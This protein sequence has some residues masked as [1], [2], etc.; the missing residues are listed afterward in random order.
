MKP[1]LNCIDN[2]VSNVSERVLCEHQSVIKQ[3]PCKMIFGCNMSLQLDRMKPK[4][5]AIIEATK[6]TDN[7]NAKSFIPGESVLI[8][9]NAGDGT[10]WIP[11]NVVTTKG[12]TMYTCASNRGQCV[13]QANNMLKNTATKCVVISI[14][15][16]QN[17]FACNF[18]AGNPPVNN[19]QA[20]DPMLSDN[21][22]SIVPA[23][24][25]KR[26]QRKKK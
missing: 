25:N 16:T 6:S 14:D 18:R 9:N 12:S 17:D 21:Q 22:R 11:A 23:T 8:R 15:L 1:D 10:K 20:A 26:D 4:P 5:N 7:P 13:C 3:I 24:H 19:I 2:N